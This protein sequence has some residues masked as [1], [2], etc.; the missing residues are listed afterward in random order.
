MDSNDSKLWK[1]AMVEEI[2]SMNKNETR[3]LVELL[4]RIKP[5]GRKNGCL[6]IN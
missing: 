3:D 6:R 1:K 5:I 2:D 4:A